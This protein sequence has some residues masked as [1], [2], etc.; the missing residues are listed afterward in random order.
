MNTKLLAYQLK[1]PGIQIVN[2]PVSTLEAIISKVI[3]ILTIIGAVYFI[4]QI[5][6]S[7]FSFMSSQGDPKALDISKKKITNNI[8][9]LAI[10]ILAYGF[11]A[12]I[13]TLLGINNVFD[14]KTVFTKI[15]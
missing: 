8:L 13:T 7:G 5:I 1:G 9:G 12:L 14:L 3:G 4:I 15:Q 10:I 6:I 11:G 2:N